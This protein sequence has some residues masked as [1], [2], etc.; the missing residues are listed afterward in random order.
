MYMSAHF[1]II[2]IGSKKLTTIYFIF[3]A[4]TKG[5]GETYYH[6][7]YLITLCVKGK[8]IDYIIYNYWSG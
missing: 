6:Y 8:K 5:R 4:I 1:L 7:I 2:V 3:Y